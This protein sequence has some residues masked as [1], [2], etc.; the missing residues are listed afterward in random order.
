M[1]EKY[2][3][4]KYLIKEKEFIPIIS[5]NF[6]SNRENDYNN[7]E[8]KYISKKYIVLNNF[9]EKFIKFIDA[10]TFCILNKKFNYYKNLVVNDNYLLFDKIIENEIHFSLLNL[11]DCSE[12]TKNDLLKELF[13]F[14]AYY[15][16]PKILLNNNNFENTIYLYENNQLSILEYNNKDNNKNII[17]QNQMTKKITIKE[18]ANKL[19]KIIDF[20]EVYSKNYEPS[21]LFVNNDEDFYTNYYCSKNPSN[22]YI[23]FEFIDEYFIGSF[24]IFYLSRRKKCK[25]KNFKVT[26]LDNNKNIIKIFEFI[27]DDI[28]SLS[29]EYNLK[30]KGK[31]LRFDLIDNYGG[32]YIIIKKINFYA[33]PVDSVQIE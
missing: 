23:V 2:L 5:S 12:E 4:I 1:G 14:K 33:N 15:Y 21:N 8:I 22:Q 32:A 31:Y 20:S 29:H 17:T 11:E 3:L 6:I 18:N 10:N 28:K 13:N 16:F 27:N 26:I 9:Q 7:Y 30:N 25:P 24:E 19:P